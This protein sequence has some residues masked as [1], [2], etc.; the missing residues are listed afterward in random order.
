MPLNL[1]FKQYSL[2]K[3]QISSLNLSPEKRDLLIALMVNKP[4]TDAQIN[5]LTKD[6]RIL[7]N[8]YKV[9][10]ES[11]QDLKEMTPEEKDSFICKL[12]GYNSAELKKFHKMNPNDV[13][14]HFQK[15]FK[16]ERVSDGGQISTERHTIPHT[17]TRTKPIKYAKPPNRS[18][19]TVH[20][21]PLEHDIGVPSAVSNAGNP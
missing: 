20:V 2:L 16:E 5:K 19:G 4:M 1:S 21:A 11:I 14:D 3:S 17:R 15:L 6:A 8:Q 9:L 7:Y 10:H 12:V 18:R 13:F